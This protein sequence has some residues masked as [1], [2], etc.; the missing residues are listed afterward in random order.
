MIVFRYDKTF[1]GLLT[2]VFDAYFRKTFPDVLLLTGEPLPLFHDEVVE[3]ITDEE[4]SGRVWA[5]LREKLSSSALSMLTVCWLSEL[6]G[7]DRMLFRYM[8]KAIDAP[9]SIELNFGDPD[10]LELSGVW[11]KVN[12]ERIRI[13]QFVRFQKTADGVFF[14]P[15]EPVHNALPLT[16]HHFKNR[17]A[18]QRWLIYDLKRQYG[19]YYDLTDVTEVTFACPEAHLITGVLDESIMAE[20]EKTFQQLW[21][22]YFKSIAIKERINPRLHK[23]HIPVRYWKYLTEKK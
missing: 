6:P 8:R 4:K 18:D 16:I 12:W 7:I 9:V 22:T 21:K 23:Q 3:V 11:K 17:F 5:G 14:A 19:Y 2:V 10:V 15:F 1:D 13:L 20:D